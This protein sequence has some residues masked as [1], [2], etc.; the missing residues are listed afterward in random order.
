[1]PSPPGNR[2]ATSAPGSKA[3]PASDSVAIRDVPNAGREQPRRGNASVLESLGHATS[4]GCLRSHAAFEAHQPVV[5]S[6]LVRLAPCGDCEGR[7]DEAIDRTTLVHHE[8][9]NMDELGS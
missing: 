3:K 4:T 1:M 9:P 5:G 6:V 7:V 8:L 2:I